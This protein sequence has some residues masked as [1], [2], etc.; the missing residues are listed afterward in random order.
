MQTICLNTVPIDDIIGLI[1]KE[2]DVST[3]AIRGQEMVPKALTAR[4]VTMLLSKEYSGRSHDVIGRALG[5]RDVH[6]VDYG[7]YRISD[8][9]RREPELDRKI[10]VIER[11][12]QRMLC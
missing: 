11:V 8:L 1:A 9:R 3:Y 6:M 12:I 10:Q 5:A 2:F 4:W 7:I